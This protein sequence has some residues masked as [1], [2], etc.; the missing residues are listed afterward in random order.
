MPATEREDLVIQQ[1]SQNHP[2]LQHRDMILGR[3]SWA[4]DTYPWCGGDSR[5]SPPR[6]IQPFQLRATYALGPKPFFGRQCSH[7]S[8]PLRGALALSRK[9]VPSSPRSAR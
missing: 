8:T 7:T 9:T 4:W 6:L 1:V 5:L 2:E 3:A